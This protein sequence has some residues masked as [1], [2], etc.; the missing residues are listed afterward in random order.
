MFLTKLKTLFKKAPASRRRKKNALTLSCLQQ[1][2]KERGLNA[3]VV[4][5]NNR[6]LE[7]DILP[8]ENL[9]RH[10]TD[11]SGSAGRLLVLPE[12]NSILFVD[13]RYELQ[14]ALEV[15]SKVTVN[16]TATKLSFPDWLK[17]KLPAYPAKI[18]FNPWCV[19]IKEIEKLQ[20]DVP[21]CQFVPV[22]GLDD[23]RRLS[24]KAFSVFAHDIEYAG[25]STE[26]KLS[27]LFAENSFQGIDALL[28]TAADS[29][30]WLMNL[31]TRCL[32]DT[33]VLRA[34]ALVGS[35]GNITLF[36]DNGDFS[37][38]SASQ[39]TLR[40]FA[41]LPG[42]LKKLRKKRLGLEM[43]TAPYQLKSLAEQYGIALIDTPDACAEMKCRKNPIE[44]S[45]IRQA[46]ICDG[47]ALTRFLIWL[48]QQKPEKLSEKIV[49]DKLRSFREKQKLFFSDSFSTI[50]AFAEH[51]AIVHYHPGAEAECPFSAGSLL[52]LDS[53][54]QYYNG[55]TDVTRTLAIGEPHQELIDACTYVLKAHIRLSSAVFPI[56][57]PGIKLDVLSREELWKH[58]MDYNHG[59]GHG[60]GCFLNVHEGPVGISS[61]YSQTGLE[62]GMILSIEPGY[63]AENRYG[64][65]IENLVEVVSAAPG[66]LTFSPL[67]LVP[68]DRCLINPKLLDTSEI[69]WLNAYH[70]R[71]RETLS[72]LLSVKEKQELEKLCTRI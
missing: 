33:P 43:S 54:A 36:A 67:T 51:G 53:G 35:D 58:G 25:I 45:G 12:G 37:Q 60:V 32:P 26:E 48:N 17:Y 7:E 62:Q 18:G 66:M 10:L 65:R 8:E 71:V 63:Y 27:E 49:V 41:E 68:Y 23:D 47:I 21:R 14:A 70:E 9:L 20:H 5:R 46:H 16:C 42:E 34:W 72:P 59:T 64:I 40:S 52:L 55:T 57:T 50:A 44:L 69:N 29:V 19:S 4:T 38:I 3:L 28:I 11:F 1:Q 22:T 39:F 31:R 61:S 30:S 15:P 2:V 24:S 56:G 6:F 13:G